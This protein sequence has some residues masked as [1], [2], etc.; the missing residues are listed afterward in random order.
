MRNLLKAEINNFK[1]VN[2]GEVTF[3]TKDGKP[4]NVTAIYGQNGS[5]K[6]TLID[7]IQ[8]FKQLSMGRSLNEELAEFFRSN[9]EAKISLTFKA[10]DGSVWVYEVGLKNTDIVSETVYNKKRLDIKRGKKIFEL[11]SDDGKAKLRST[12][13]LKSFEDAATVQLRHRASVFF[14]EDFRNKIAEKEANVDELISALDDLKRSAYN[15]VI[16][17]DK[18]N[19]LMAGGSVMPLSFSMAKISNN[20]A[21]SHIA[22]TIP[23]DIDYN[24]KNRIWYD[25]EDADLANNILDKISYALGMIVPGLSLDVNIV[26]EN[27]FIT[28]ENKENYGVDVFV[29][30]D[31]R[32]IPM[33]QESL[34]VQKIIS[35]LSL[36]LE[37]YNN[38]DV[39]VFI[40]ELDAGIYEFL[41]GEIV[42]VMSSGADGQLI[43]TSHNLRVLET[44][45]TDKVVLTTINPDDSYTRFK[46]PIGPT[47]NLRKLYMKSIQFGP[48]E[49]ENVLANKINSSDITL[50]FMGSNLEINETSEENDY[51]HKIFLDAS[52]IEEGADNE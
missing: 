30:R 22:G 35:I 51:F 25:K 38:E 52:A 29:T 12:I 48:D 1:N 10:T 34:G 47:N 7:A 11:I 14:S 28:D 6:T 26:Q 33:K 24:E 23:L 42:E 46:G 27:P 13:G 9:T 31:G 5:G 45:P 36:L 43:F 16:H 18:M 41:L 21:T 4:S 50:A 20:N 19:G 2:R 3:L 15:I 17:T 37:V 8:V 32:T 40:D 49:G 44:L 39:I